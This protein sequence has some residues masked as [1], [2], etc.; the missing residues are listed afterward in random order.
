MHQEKIR[1]HKILPNETEMLCWKQIRLLGH[2]TFD[3]LSKA[4]HG[5]CARTVE[6]KIQEDYKIHGIKDTLVDFEY[7]E[8]EILI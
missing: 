6:G 1:G 7:H 3:A 5:P 2:K 8:N 4:F